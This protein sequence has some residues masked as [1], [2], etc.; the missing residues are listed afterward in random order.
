MSNFR[1]S[2]GRRIVA[3]GGT[4][5]LGAGPEGEKLLELITQS[6]TAQAIYVAAE[7][8]IADHLRDGPRSSDQLAAATGADAPSLYRLLRALTTID[9]CTQR[10]DGTFAITPMGLL[11]AA[12]VPESLRSWAIWWGKHLWPVWGNLLYSVTTGR[13][14]RT[15]LKGT[16]GFKHLEHDPQAAATFHRALAELTQLETQSIIAAYD[17]SGFNRIVD[18][19]GGYGQ[20]L[21]AILG[22]TAEARGILLDLPHAIDGAKAY[23]QQL[24]LTDRCEFVAGDFFQSVPGG[25]DAYILKSVLHDWDD[26]RCR[27]FL[28][29]CRRAMPQ[30]ATFLA[31]ERML[32]ERL[33]CS[34]SHQSA[35]RS[36]LT[37]LAA[38]AAMERSET[39]FRELLTSSGFKIQRIE[40]AGALSI[41]EA[42]CQ[43]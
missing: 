35:A 20:L 11:L 33:T 36:D 3:T 42:V 37:M 19:G 9:L 18:L 2:T 29:N 22:K 34:L 27:Q 7:L 24:Q 38:L 4:E 16:E 14:A 25:G 41:I 40:Q 43:V 5:N 32:P 6:W 12:D 28:G 39:Q 21:G 30:G 15:M 31:I 13:S 8:G 1:G 10:E 17:F 26:E 23:L